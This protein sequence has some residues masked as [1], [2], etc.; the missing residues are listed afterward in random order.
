VAAAGA[1][2][3]A[4]ADIQH[5]L[6]APGEL[7]QGRVL[8]AQQLPSEPALLPLLLLLLQ[9]W[10]LLLLLRLALL[11]LLVHAAAAAADSRR[12]RVAAARCL[13]VH[14]EPLL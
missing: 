11:L 5:T 4:A 9:P 7:L 13:E 8:F 12:G 2:Q 14:Q 10:T 6:D 3:T 1:A